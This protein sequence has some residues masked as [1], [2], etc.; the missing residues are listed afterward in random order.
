MQRSFEDWLRE[1]PL[2]DGAGTDASRPSEVAG[3]AEI[4]G[5]PVVPAGNA[6]VFPIVFPD[7]T[8]E[9]IPEEASEK[10]LRE[11]PSETS[12]EPSASPREQLPENI[13]ERADSMPLPE[14]LAE[15]TDEPKVP[16]EIIRRSPENGSFDV[17]AGFPETGEIRP[18]T[19]GRTT[20][21]ADFREIPVTA[22]LEEVPLSG[23]RE[24]PVR[25]YVPPQDVVSDVEQQL[26]AEID[27]TGERE[28]RRKRRVVFGA[29]IFC[30][31][32]ALGF[33]WGTRTTPAELND[34]GAILLD[35]GK[36]EEALRLFRKAES[37][38]PDSLPILLNIAKSLERLGRH[39]DA[40]DAYFRCLQIAPSDPEIH[41]RLGS[42]FRTL[43]SPEK[44][45]RSFQDVL[46]R[47]PGNARALL[48]LG[49][50]YLDRADA[51]QAVPVL[52]RALEKDADMQEARTALEKAKAI[53][54]EQKRLLEAQKARERAAEALERGRI[55]HMLARDGEAESCFEE[56]LRFDPENEAAQLSLANVLKK[57]GRYSRARE[58]YEK[59]LMKSPEQ[60]EARLGLLE[61]LK[62]EAS[63]ERPVSGDATMQ[64]APG[65]AQ[66]GN[67]GTEKTP[68]GAPK[69]GRK[70]SSPSRRSSSSS[71]LGYPKD[72]VS[73]TRRA[74]ASDAPARREDRVSLSRIRD[75]LE[76]LLEGRAAET[77]QAQRPTFR[78]FP[79]PLGEY[80][81]QRLPLPDSVPFRTYPV[82]FPYI[83]AV[84]SLHRAVSVNP[85]RQDLYFAIIRYRRKS[86][87][88]RDPGALSG[89]L[90]PEEEGLYLLLLAHALYST[91]SAEQ[92]GDVLRDAR[93]FM[94]NDPE[95]RQ[96]VR[97]LSGI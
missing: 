68:A 5:L 71:A 77:A 22:A 19:A 62:L 66:T 20:G 81:V 51:A 36:A 91:G 3:N 70:R 78:P 52:E 84:S 34:R 15:R 14:K 33:W 46:Q 24:I 48:G 80:A 42:L 25:R 4:L 29:L 63:G 26:L 83:M 96:V 59:V 27:E 58:L 50:S 21:E 61:T 88:R 7:R 72:F 54:G 53:L 67:N 55:A 47:D 12:R 35:S 87:A 8:P 18:A 43:E 1:K 10:V 2:S 75:P 44:A 6:P 38:S 40:V 31:V 64:T 57:T 17:P 30:A 79:F 89:Y 65:D 95:C 16:E 56:A 60:Q 76:I 37:K 69:P 13:P 93:R 82:L 74:A 45:V 39:G 94:P 28:A 86:G 49:L 97:F 23:E 85:D 90:S 41:L 11:I 73:Q 92:A 9:E 32:A